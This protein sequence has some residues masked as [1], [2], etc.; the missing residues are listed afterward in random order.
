MNPCGLLRRARVRDPA[1]EGD[2]S[3][4]SGALVRMFGDVV[5]ADG[6][7]PSVGACRN[8]LGDHI[9]KRAKVDETLVRHF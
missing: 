3:G 5:D 9:D 2:A 6:K 8:G 7:G 1:L 4:R